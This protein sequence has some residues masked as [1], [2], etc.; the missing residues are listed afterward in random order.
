[1]LSSRHTCTKCCNCPSALAPKQACGRS[2]SVAFRKEVKACTNLRGDCGEDHLERASI[3]CRSKK[4]KPDNGWSVLPRSV[5]Q[6][7]L[8]TMMQRL[9][10]K[11]KQ[12]LEGFVQPLA[13]QACSSKSMETR[14]AHLVKP[15]RCPSQWLGTTRRAK[16]Q[17][18]E[19]VLSRRLGPALPSIR[20]E[21]HEDDCH[22][23]PKVSGTRATWRR[24]PKTRT[25]FGS[26][27]HCDGHEGLPCTDP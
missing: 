19:L 14:F 2:E 5:A 13:A 25:A 15:Q 23:K 18:L 10:K 16:P 11:K 20:Q 7:M 1:M 26:A 17:N 12:L 27:C 4:C 6:K 8:T 22:R 9:P 21:W 3:A 24:W